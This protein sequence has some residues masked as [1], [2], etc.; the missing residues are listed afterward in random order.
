VR[1]AAYLAV[2]PGELLEVCAAVDVR[3]ARSACNGIF[4]QEIRAVRL[5][6]IRRQELRVRVGEVQQR[7]VAE[8]LRLVERVGGLRVGVGGPQPAARRGGEGE[9]AEEFAALQASG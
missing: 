2:A 9:Q 8:R 1:E 4:L 5:P 6:E 3:E 7:D